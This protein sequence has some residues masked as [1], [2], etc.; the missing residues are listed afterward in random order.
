MFVAVSCG[1][2]L[3]A[4][5]LCTQCAANAQPTVCGGMWAMAECSLSSVAGPGSLYAV[6]RERAAQTRPD[7]RGLGGQH[8]IWLLGVND[9]GDVSAAT[10]LRRYLAGCRDTRLRTRCSRT[11]GW[12]ARRAH[13][14]AHT[15]THTHIHTLRCHLRL[16]LGAPTH[17]R[18]A[19]HPLLCGTEE[20][21]HLVLAMPRRVVDVWLHSS[22]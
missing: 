1:P 21:F 20:L 14:R 3:R 11:E 5:V 10:S 19:R 15:Y 16:F 13:T 18:K 12:R 4:L 9:D 17:P 8:L 6:C 7:C 22:M 2:W